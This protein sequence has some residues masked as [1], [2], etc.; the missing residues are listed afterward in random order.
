MNKSIAILTSSRADFG[1]YLPLLNLL[2]K[3]AS[4]DLKL[5]VFGTHLS[6]I[7]G[8]TVDEIIAEGF[9]ADYKLFA[10]ITNN[11]AEDIANNYAEYTQLFSTF[12]ANHTFDL[13]LALGD[14]FEMAAAVMAGIPYN[15]KF[16][17]LHAGETTLG[18]IDNIYRHCITLASSICF[19]STQMYS[20]RVHQLV[21]STVPVINVGALS[22]DGLEK[23]ELPSK[24]NL[25]QQFKLDF[26]KPLIMVVFHPETVEPSKNEIYINEVLKAIELMPEYAFAIN[27]PNADT[28]ADIIRKAILD[29]K[30][31]HADNQ[32][33]SV[34]EHFGKRNYF[35]CLKHAN[36]LIGNSSS[37]IIEA[38]TFNKYVLN[39]GNRQKGRAKSEN[40]KDCK[41]DFNEIINVSRELI[42]FGSFTGQNIYKNKQS[43]ALLIIEAIQSNHS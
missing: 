21:E 19:T 12:W 41:I 30:N 7:H 9:N 27:M 28:G 4:F 26:S 17:H 33:I 38:A 8:H 34:I 35:A 37:G 25:A 24:E 20:E 43:S 11:R 5:I 10:E 36:L 3:D 22:L 1:I 13:V 32:S 6:T 16:A 29:F 42:K 15:I 39:M 14:R 31:K 18:A 40:T 2:K 23:L